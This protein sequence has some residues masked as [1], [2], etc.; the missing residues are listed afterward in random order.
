MSSLLVSIQQ[1][2]SRDNRKLSEKVWNYAR[3]YS[4]IFRRYII[5][6]FNPHLMKVV[7][8]VCLSSG[9]IEKNH[10]L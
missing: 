9:F 3:E 1:E 2:Y 7:F 8:G 10:R 6:K 4:K 5:K